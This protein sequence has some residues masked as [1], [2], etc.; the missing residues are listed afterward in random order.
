MSTDEMLS[1]LPAIYLGSIVMGGVLRLEV[2]IT[3]RLLSWFP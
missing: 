3:R 1:L 2:M